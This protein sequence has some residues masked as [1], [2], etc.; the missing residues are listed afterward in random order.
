VA[1]VRPPRQSVGREEAPLRE[2]E[3]RVER[4]DR[5]VVRRGD[6]GGRER[7]GLGRGRA[8]GD[9]EARDRCVKRR[10]VDARVGRSRGARRRQNMTK[11]RQSSSA[12]TGWEW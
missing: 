2:R 4:R 11:R 6:A 8:C 7:G 10:E 1:E 5:A 3:P 9:A 12:G